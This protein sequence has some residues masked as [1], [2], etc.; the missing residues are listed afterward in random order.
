[1]H[2]K[3]YVNVLKICIINVRSKI[4]SLLILNSA[5]V[6]YYICYIKILYQKFCSENQLP[7]TLSFYFISPYFTLQLTQYYNIILNDTISLRVNGNGV[8]E[9]AGG[10]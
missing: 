6:I 2:V 5:Y 3:H 7:I 9:N 10:I 4:K 8:R 1:M